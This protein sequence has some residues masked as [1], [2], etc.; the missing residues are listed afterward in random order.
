MREVAGSEEEAGVV[1]GGE[2]CDEAA[3][4]DEDLRSTNGIRRI[5]ELEAG[6]VVE[7]A[8]AAPCFPPPKAWLV[9]LEEELDSRGGKLGIVGVL[10]GVVIVCAGAVPQAK[11]ISTPSSLENRVKLTRKL[12]HIAPDRRERRRILT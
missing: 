11:P 9:A 12:V 8:A 6:V 4:S 2:G 3:A 7:P 1:V 10:L 5:A